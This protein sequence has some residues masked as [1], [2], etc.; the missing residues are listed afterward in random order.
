[1]TELVTCIWF[2]HGEAGKAAA[3]R[4]ASFPQSGAGLGDL[5]AIVEV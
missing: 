2:D 4:A 1:M 3:G 5:E